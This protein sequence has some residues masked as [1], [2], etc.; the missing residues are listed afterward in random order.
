MEI[1][2]LLP[3]SALPSGILVVTKIQSAVRVEAL[4]LD[5]DVPNLRGAKIWL[6]RFH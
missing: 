2:S 1:P 5:E 6:V 3:I 4:A